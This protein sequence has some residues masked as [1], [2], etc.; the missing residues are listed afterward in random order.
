LWRRTKVAETKALCK[1]DCSNDRVKDEKGGEVRKKDSLKD[2]E[3]KTM[4]G[5][6]NS[7]IKNTQ[8]IPGLGFLKREK[9]AIMHT[10]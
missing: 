9:A 7:L 5:A 10:T 3:G 1:P 8:E 4:I 2:K 6:L